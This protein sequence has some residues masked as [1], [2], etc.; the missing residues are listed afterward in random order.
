MHPFR[1]EFSRIPLRRKSPP[2]AEF[3][4]IPLEQTLIAHTF[5]KIKERPKNNENENSYFAA[6]VLTGNVRQRKTGFPLTLPRRTAPLMQEYHVIRENRRQLQ[7]GLCVENK[8]PHQ[9]Q[10]AKKWQHEPES[11]K[12]RRSWQIKLLYRDAYFSEGN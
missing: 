4:R 5:L 6:D 11:S 10:P 9:Y 12:C 7:F 2:V 8:A 1:T 3:V